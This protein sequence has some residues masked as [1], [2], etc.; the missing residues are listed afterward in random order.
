M[1]Q[2]QQSLA[3][4]P[5]LAVYATISPVAP[6]Q[7]LRPRHLLGRPHYSRPTGSIDHVTAAAER[8]NNDNVKAPRRCSRAWET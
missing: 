3:K 7:P 1:P 4:P 8:G 5:A 6:Y 2:E